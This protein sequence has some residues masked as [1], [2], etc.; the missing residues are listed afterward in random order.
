MS[1][2]ITIT[3]LGN[4]YEACGVELTPEVEAS[5]MEQDVDDNGHL[6]AKEFT[7]WAGGR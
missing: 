3:E 4:L 2:G 7:A 6:N 5:F 1:S